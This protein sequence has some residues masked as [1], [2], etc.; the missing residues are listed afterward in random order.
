MHCKPSSKC[1][2]QE[3]DIGW[4]TSRQHGKKGGNIFR[5]TPPQR[6]RRH[7]SETVHLEDGQ[8]LIVRAHAPYRRSAVGQGGVH[9]VADSEETLSAERLLVQANART[10]S[11]VRVRSRRRDIAT[12]AVALLTVSWSR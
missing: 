11:G 2:T 7:V 5:H 8:S 4:Q 10:Y 9:P 12:R 3:A 1:G 6:G